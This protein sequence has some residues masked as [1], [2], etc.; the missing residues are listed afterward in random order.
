MA[1]ARFSCGTS[2]DLGTLAPVNLARAKPSTMAGKI[3]AGVGEELLDAVAAQRCQYNIAGSSGHLGWGSTRWLAVPSHQ[4]SF[5][6]ADLAIA[7]QRG[8]SSAIR[9]ARS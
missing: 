8:I 5:T 4:S 6:L 1:T 7:V 2:T 3:R 9:L